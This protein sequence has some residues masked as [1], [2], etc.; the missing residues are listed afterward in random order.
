MKQSKKTWEE[1]FMPGALD[2]TM[3][4]RLQERARLIGKTSS[5]DLPRLEAIFK[6]VEILG[7]LLH[8][9]RQYLESPLTSQRCAQMEEELPDRE[10]LWLWEHGLALPHEVAEGKMANLIQ[11]YV[12]A[13]RQEQSNDVTYQLDN[14]ISM[15]Y[16]ALTG[17]QA[18]PDIMQEF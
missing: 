10:T 1:P 14:D 18:P 16:R 4:K 5:A 9:T 11:T 12:M 15:L 17:Q 13:L 2:K 3:K 6:R 8:T 7:R